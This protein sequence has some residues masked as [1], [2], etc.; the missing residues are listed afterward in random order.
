M[1]ELVEVEQ[2]PCQSTHVEVA[3]GFALRVATRRHLLPFQILLMEHIPLR[4]PAP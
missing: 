4:Q 3:D 1:N 2:L